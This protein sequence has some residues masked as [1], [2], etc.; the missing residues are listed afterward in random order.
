MIEHAARTIWAQLQRSE[1]AKGTISL[2]SRNLETTVLEMVKGGWQNI[3][4]LL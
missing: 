3:Y 2:I 4:R 1:Q